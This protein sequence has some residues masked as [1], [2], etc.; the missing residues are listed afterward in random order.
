MAG[1]I[2]K[3]GNVY[4]I[5]YD[6]PRGADGRR[7]QRMLACPGLNKKQA[8]ERLRQTLSQI[9]NGTYADPSA[10]TLGQYLDDW[11]ERQQSR[12]SPSSVESYGGYIRRHIAPTLGQTPL[13]KLTPA[14]I[15]SLYTKLGRT[16][17]PK[18]I[19]TLH[20][21]LHSALRQ[22]CRLQMLPRNPSDYIELPRV[23]RSDVQTASLEDIARLRTALEGTAYYL[24]V[25]V[26]IAT[27]M[28]RGE[29]LG[30]RWEDYNPTAR[31]LVVRRSA[32]R[33]KGK[34]YVKATK[35]GASRVVLLPQF[36][37]DKLSQ[38]QAEATSEWVFPNRFGWVYNPEAFGV[39][40][41]A[42]ADRAGV[43]VTL[44]GL[45]H[46]QA[47]LLIMAGVPVKVVSERLGHSTVKVTQDIYA[48]VLPHMQSEAADLLEQ[49]FGDSACVQNV[50][51]AAGNP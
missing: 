39:A 45:R 28:R 46:T 51:K 49:W 7:R 33:M 19:V 16:L 29:V 12:L 9:H 38:R 6:L 22:G 26:I 42:I 10:I 32:A 27:G 31:T 24:P 37:A 23:T 3:R 13:G 11:L 1:G 44:H 15:Q 4:Y 43:S 21:M 14:A 34:T 36:V 47:T 20:G 50:C 8:E 5:R 48:H 17:A 41:R 25:L 35:T 2:V 40:F 18:T 30:L